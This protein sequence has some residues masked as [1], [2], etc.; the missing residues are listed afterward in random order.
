MT[1]SAWVLS[2]RKELRALLPP[3]AAS[4]AVVFAAPFV[5]AP[6][7]DLSFVVS[8]YV[9]GAL[10]IGAMSV[11][12]EYTFRT[13]SVAL[14]RPVS[15]RAILGAKGAAVATALGLLVAASLTRLPRGWTWGADDAGVQAFIVLPLLGAVCVAPWLTMVCRS[16]LAGIVFTGVLPPMA[17]LMA[18]WVHWPAM[19]VLW[20]TSIVLALVGAVAGWRQFM[21]LEA[22]EGPGAAVGLPQWLAF[23]RSARDTPTERASVWWLLVTKELRLQLMAFAVAGLFV[24]GYAAFRLVPLDP[25][26]SR[27][28]S[29]AVAA[30]YAAVLVVLVG[31]LACAEEHRLGTVSWQVLLPVSARRQWFVKVA[32]VLALSVVL[33]C[34]L[35]AVLVALAEGETRLGWNGEM[36]AVVAIASCA[37]LYLSS[38][39][40]DGLRAA[41]L[42]PVVIGAA[43]PLG[44][45]GVS[46]GNLVSKVTLPYVD[47]MVGRWAPD[48]FQS[49][50]AR[51]LF[52]AERYFS[53]VCLAGV[54]LLLLRAAF[55]NYRTGH[56]NARRILQQAAGVV[57]CLTVA[58]VL[59]GLLATVRTDSTLRREWSRCRQPGGVRCSAYLGE[60]PPFRDFFQPPAAR[61]PANPQ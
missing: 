25:D 33:G 1:T 61:R 23:G 35:P 44:V 40:K 57:A 60:G 17:A 13:L 49:T 15:R 21:T 56:W 48:G 11:G 4:V 9:L 59:A 34:V 18:S 16:T 39:S 19:P 28:L 22:I 8:A 12:H 53:W 29:E 32:V 37:A 14:T 42:A 5:V 7:Q 51:W 55:H 41:L 36:I 38:I 30:L 50:T 3:L 24:V 27:N 10:A 6:R 54:A 26:A 52:D 58:V 45:L 20:L 43:I 2:V 46:L 31:A 47:A